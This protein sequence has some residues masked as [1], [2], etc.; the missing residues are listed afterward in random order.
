MSTPQTPPAVDAHAPSEARHAVEG[1]PGQGA[2]LTP[3]PGLPPPPGLGHGS[4]TERAPSQGWDDDPDV[5]RHD[6]G[7]VAK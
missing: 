2:P 1:D 6:F 4:E 3:A 5:A 7:E